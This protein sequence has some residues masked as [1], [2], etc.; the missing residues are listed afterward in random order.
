MLDTIKF[1][2]MISRTKVEAIKKRPDQDFL[3]L[4][5]PPFFAG[6]CGWRSCVPQT[7]RGY[8]T[9]TILL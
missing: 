2:W 5:L 9:K 8:L 1:D 7:I 6:E 3:Y 4:I